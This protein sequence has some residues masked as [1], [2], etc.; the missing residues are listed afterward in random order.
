MTPPRPKLVGP[1]YIADQWRGNGSTAGALTAFAGFAF[2]L[3][4][5]AVGLAAPGLDLSARLQ[6][7]LTGLGVGGGLIA[8]G[9]WK[10]R[11][12]A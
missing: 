7:L 8:F 1:K 11:R 6:A 2:L 12:R 10:A 5:G 3:F 9:L 4:V